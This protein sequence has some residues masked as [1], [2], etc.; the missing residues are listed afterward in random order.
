MATTVLKLVQLSN[1]SA[2]WRIILLILQKTKYCAMTVLCDIRM[3]IVLVENMMCPTFH[4]RKVVAW[5][6]AERHNGLPSFLEL[7]CENDDALHLFFRLCTMH[8]TLYG[9]RGSNGH[10]DGGTSC[11]T[12]AINLKAVRATRA[13]HDQLSRFCWC[14]ILGRS[15]LEVLSFSWDFAWL[16]LGCVGIYGWQRR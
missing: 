1:G 4:D 9:V 11:N 7:H 12:S 10:Y 6:L 5:E 16:G 14:G 3:L 15:L 2:S 13:G 8:V